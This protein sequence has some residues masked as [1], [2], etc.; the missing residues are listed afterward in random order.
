MLRICPQRFHTTLSV[1]VALREI[2]LPSL[3]DL[4]AVT[5]DIEMACILYKA[6]CY[7]RHTGFRA[8]PNAR[9]LYC[10]T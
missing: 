8:I 2:L 6:E 5:H 1:V 9:R 4:L 3:G 7:E 10:L